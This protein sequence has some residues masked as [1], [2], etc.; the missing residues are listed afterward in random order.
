MGELDG[1]E[2]GTGAV[3]S[4]RGASFELSQADGD[5]IAVANSTESLSTLAAA[6]N[7]ADVVSTLEGEGPFTV[8]L[9]TNA[10]FQKLDPLLMSDLLKEGNS[11]KLKGIL[12]YHVLP[13][14]STA[15]NL[16]AAITSAGTE[17]SLSTANGAPLKASAPDGNVVI[18]GKAKVIQAD[19]E[20]SNGVIH[21]IDTVLLPP[22]V[23]RRQLVVKS[24]KRWGL[25]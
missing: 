13:G 19:I 22:E 10:A 15:A 2:T 3:S 11:E 6:V 7:A 25:A 12:K 23:Q 14:K 8:F 20:A 5:I 18:N 16:T 24:L 4:G 17:V 21:I 1:H 9:P